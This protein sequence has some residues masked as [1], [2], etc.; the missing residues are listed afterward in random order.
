MFGSAFIYGERWGVFIMNDS[1]LKLLFDFE[2][3]SF[4]DIHD[5]FLYKGIVLDYR[6][7]AELLTKYHVSGKLDIY[8]DNGRF[9]DT[10]YMK[11]IENG[12]KVRTYLI[13]NK[14]VISKWYMKDVLDR[15]TSRTKLLKYSEFGLFSCDT[16]FKILS[17]HV[18]YSRQSKTRDSGFVIYEFE[19]D[20]LAL[21]FRQRYCIENGD[22]FS[23]NSPSVIWADTDEY[24]TIYTKT[25]DFISC[26]NDLLE[27]NQNNLKELVDGSPLSY[28]Q[29]NNNSL[30]TIQQSKGTMSINR[31]RFLLSKE[32]LDIKGV[33][34]ILRFLNL[35]TSLYET[36]EVILDIYLTED[37]LES[38]YSIDSFADLDK[39]W[40]TTKNFLNRFRTMIEDSGIDISKYQAKEME[41]EQSTYTY[42]QVL[43]P[44][45]DIILSF[46]NEYQNYKEKTK[47]S[48]IDT[49]LKNKY[50]QPNYSRD[51]HRV[52]KKLIKAH[53]KLKK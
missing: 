46:D 26:F 14:R 35:S 42:S 8:F 31:V 48:T 52:L 21:K 4:K 29:V 17:G 44:Y 9:Q 18:S 25:F 5:I 50:P 36:K 1:K 3:L 43:K 49:W 6:D 39:A 19:C 24:L 15:F 47:A 28:D 33:D 37:T 51:E 20:G 11:D 12:H 10:D 53:Y 40:F 32:S 23:D 16:K 41:E 13:H 30:D 22:G 2:W 7:T 27:L 45:N 34:T 38:D